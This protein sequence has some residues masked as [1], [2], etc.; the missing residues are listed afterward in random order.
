SDGRAYSPA[1]AFQRA[2]MVTD[3]HYFHTAGEADLDLPAGRATIEAIRG[4]EYKPKSV[5]IDVVAGRTQAAT[6]TLERLVDLP[7][8]GWY[9]G[10]GH[11]HDLHQ[12]FG[13]THESFFQQLVAEDLNV[14][15]ALI[16]MDGTR[17]MGRWT[18]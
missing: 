6:V 5:T 16:H 14:T 4:W 13:Q 8:R 18:D 1:G 17:I 9:S 7:A 3:R 2:M 15:H 11:V 12:G 10:D